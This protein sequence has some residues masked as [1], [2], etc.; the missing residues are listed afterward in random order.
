VVLVDTLDG[1]RAMAISEDPAL[2]AAME[3]TEWV[4]RTVTV[5]DN[6]LTG[7]PDETNFRPKPRADLP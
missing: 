2:I 7:S 1:K 6:L 5:A 4:G 3:Q